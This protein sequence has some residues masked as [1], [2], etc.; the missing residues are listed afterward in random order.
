[1]SA[2]RKY[3]RGINA[4]HNRDLDDW[5]QY[6]VTRASA[7]RTIGA[8]REAAWA[9]MR[10]KYSEHQSLILK[11]RAY[12]EFYQNQAVDGPRIAI[13]MVGSMG[14]L[15]LLPTIAGLYGLVAYNVK[16]DGK[17]PSLRPQKPRDRDSH[18]AG[19]GERGRA[20]SG[21]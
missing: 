14:A 13:D 11:T 3:L 16:P 9:A 20:A 19:R 10:G 12:A 21:G 1:M 5:I 8:S 15:A 18:S 6:I 4:I 2:H 7:M 17:P